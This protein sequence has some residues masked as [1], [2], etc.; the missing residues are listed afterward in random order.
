MKACPPC[1]ADRMRAG[2]LYPTRRL[3]VCEPRTCAH[4]A[5][6]AIVAE[7]QQID[8]EFDAPLPATS[9]RKVKVFCLAHNATALKIPLSA[10][11]PAPA[12]IPPPKPAKVTAP[13]ELTRKV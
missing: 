5:Q 1:G 3:C 9:D 10:A 4:C 13:V 7:F 2:I 12:P 11:R 6:A 8:S